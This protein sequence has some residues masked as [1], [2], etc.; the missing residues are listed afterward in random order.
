MLMELGEGSGGSVRHTVACHTHELV[1]LSRRL[2]AGTPALTDLHQGNGSRWSSCLVRTAGAYYKIGP[3][4]HFECKD[5]GQ[6]EG[7]NRQGVHEE[8]SGNNRH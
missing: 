2:Q 5:Q 6:G 4:D 1:Q 3:A 7:E 8:V